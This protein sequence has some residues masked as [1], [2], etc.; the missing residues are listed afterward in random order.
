LLLIA[1]L[2]TLYIGP[3]GLNRVFN[4]SI[5]TRAVA[6]GI[7]LNV[8]VGEVQLVRS[9]QLLE[10]GFQFINNYN[11]IYYIFYYPILIEQ[12]WVLA[13]YMTAPTFNN[14]RTISSA[15]QLY[16]CND[17]MTT[18]IFFFAFTISLICFGC[19]FWHQEITIPFRSQLQEIKRWSSLIQ[20]QSPLNQLMID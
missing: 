6:I 13:N 14:D 4:L 8:V 17:R 3:K 12:S 10:S 15:C 9:S 1:L 5:T 19:Q 20:R 16:G 18:P 7:G 11:K 2:C